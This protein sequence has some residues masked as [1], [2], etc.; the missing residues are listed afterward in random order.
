M[1]ILR[2]QEVNINET[3]AFQIGDQIKLGKYTATCQ[4]VTDKATIFLLDQ[5]LD[6]A[7]RMNPKDTNQGGYEHSEL[8]RKIGNPR[9]IAKDDNFRMVRGRLLPFSNGDLL[10]LPTVGEIFGS[11][12]F[13]ERDGA[14]QW[15]LMKKRCNRIAERDGGEEYESGWLQNKVQAE[16]IGHCF[17]AVR[18]DGQ[19]E[20]E[21]AAEASGVRLVFQLC[22]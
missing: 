22:L 8:R 14:K 1:K 21:S 9:F 17:A 19:A 20:C 7:Y 15:E 18:Y 11:D 12:P 4:K 6:E 10:R 3:S 13:Y 16:G 2:K 5:Y